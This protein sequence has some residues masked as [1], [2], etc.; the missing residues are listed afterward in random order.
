MPI[1]PSAQKAQRVSL[2]K[3]IVNRPTRSLV[4]TEVNKAKDAILKGDI[5]AAEVAV[6]RAVKSL[7]K[8]AQ[9]G[10]IHPNNTA[11]RKSRLVKEFNRMKA[12]APPE[13]EEDTP[14]VTDR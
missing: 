11:R 3:Q 6:V 10:V 9:K 5:G 2:R 8:A 13:K 14:E 7:D 4:R 1:S 12:A